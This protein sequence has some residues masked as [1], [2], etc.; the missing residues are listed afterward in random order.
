MES[1]KIRKTAFMMFKHCAK[2]FEYFFFRDPDYDAYVE[3]EPDELSPTGKGTIFHVGCDEFFGKLDLDEMKR[4]DSEADVVIYMK[5]KL[6]K[7]ERLDDW[8]QYFAELEAKRFMMC[9][10]AYP[11]NWKKVFMPVATELYVNLPGE[12]PRTGHVDRLDWLPAEKALCVVEYKTGRSY[13]LSKDRTLTGL[14]A[15]CGWYA[16]ILQKLKTYD[17]PVIYWACINPMKK[18]YH[19][20]RFHAMS[21]KSVEK[22]YQKLITAIKNKGPFDRTLSPLCGWCK[23]SSDCLFNGYGEGEFG[24][25]IL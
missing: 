1:K 19:V 13:D 15:E 21:L 22:Q 4:L 24:K 14:R 25:D 18:Q 20:E 17:L 7:T 5:S 8:F 2:Q 12:Y 6:P 11:D 16:L 9:I 10:D 3:A 23:Y